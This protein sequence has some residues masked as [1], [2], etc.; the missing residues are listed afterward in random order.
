MFP[1]MGALPPEVQQQIQ[2]L[3]QDCQRQLAELQEQVTVEQI[4]ELFKSQRLRPFALDIETDST[5]EPDQIA[6]RQARAEFSAALSPV[7]QQGVMAMQ[8]APD[9]APFIA[10]SVRFIAN[11]FKL[12]RSMDEAI[13]RLAEGWENYQP[14]PEPGGEDP[15]IAQLQAETEKIKAEAAQA[16]GQAD[17]Q[18]AQLKLQGEQMKAQMGQ[19]EAGK[20]QA[21]TDK[22]RAE[23]QKIMSEI[24]TDQAAVQIDQQKLGLEA[25]GM[26]ADQ[27]MAQEDH[28]MQREQMGHDAAMADKQF[29]A[30]QQQAKVEGKREDKRLAFEAKNSDRQHSLDKQAAQKPKPN[31]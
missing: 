15:A 25:Q 23:I 10:E 14:K 12:D 1:E 7:I 27:A 11:G 26:Q 28:A 16:K 3:E 21:E 31:G 6:E 4:E 13:D 30:D 19:L 18:I 17:I 24:Q 9:L 2:Q 20:T 8:M 29:N 22:L 5:I